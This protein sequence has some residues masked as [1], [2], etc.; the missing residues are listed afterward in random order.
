MTALIG[1]LFGALF[2]LLMASLTIAAFVFWI[3]MLVDCVMN[4]G[5]DLTE[6]VVWA[7]IIALTHFIGALIYFIAARPRGKLA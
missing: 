2:F 1:T 5:I 4:R 7:V 3:W 6:K